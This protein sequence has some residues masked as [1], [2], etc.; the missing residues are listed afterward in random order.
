MQSQRSRWLVFLPLLACAPSVEPAKLD[1]FMTN[2]FKVI[3]DA[4]K[5]E[6]DGKRYLLE[7]HVVPQADVQVTDGVVRMDMYETIDAGGEGVGSG[8][9]ITLRNGEHVTLDP[10]ASGKDAKRVKLR[11]STG[12]ATAMDRLK[13]MVDLKVTHHFQNGVAAGCEVRVVELHRLA[14]A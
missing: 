14:P 4:C 9:W 12:D 11:T 8:V 7:G 10:G 5:V 13:V 1:H 6:N 3:A 2:S